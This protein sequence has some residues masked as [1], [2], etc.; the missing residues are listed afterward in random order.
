MDD[1]IVAAVSP[2]WPQ[3]DEPESG[4]FVK[5]R[6]MS[7]ASHADVS[8]LHTLPWFPLLRR[9]YRDVTGC[10][11][12]R[13]VRSM[14]MFYIPA[15]FKHLD[16]FWSERAVEPWL[17]R[18]Q[19]VRGLSLIDAHFGYPTGVG[20]Y[21]AGRRLGVPVFITIRG[22]ESDE[23]RDRRIGPQL[24]EALT[25]CAGV[26]A[27]SESLKE[28]VVAQGVPADQVCVI[29]NA[30]D[31]SL[32]CAG[33][34][35][36]ARRKVGLPAKGRVVLSVGHLNERKGAHRLIKAFAKAREACADAELV[37]V[38]GETYSE[39]RYV[40]RLKRM[41]TK[42]GV[43]SAVRFVG[44]IPPES[45][46]DWM[47][48]ADVFALASRREGCCNVVLEAVACGLPVV[49]TDVGDNSRYV[50]PD[51]GIVVPADD[52]KALAEGLCRILRGEYERNSISGGSDWT[53]DAVARSTIEFFSSRLGDFH[54]GVRPRRTADVPVSA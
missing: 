15:I 7:V 19:Q 14:R 32:F 22:V 8:V 34:Q 36:E 38:G 1:L 5:R 25:E 9:S 37:L 26:I 50:T 18:I 40:P 35:C 13:E 11:E 23:I 20:C 45:V 46:G 49:V 12:C 31:E 2:M 39:P 21:R 16:G 29:P 54:S 24:K 44:R 4:V 27:V 10:A 43:Q 41:A 48:A 42:L 30:V 47:R 28:A 51:R 53:W 52:P 17:R 33:D 6:V 3:K